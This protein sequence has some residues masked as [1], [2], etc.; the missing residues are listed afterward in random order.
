MG[1][2]ATDCACADCVG[3]DC[4]DC[5]DPPGSPIYVQLTVDVPLID[6]TCIDDCD[7]GTG[8]ESSIAIVN[9]PT[10]NGVHILEQTGSFCVWDKEI[11]TADSGCVRNFYN[12]TGCTSLSGTS[13]FDWRLS[14][15]RTTTHDLVQISGR[16][17]AIGSYYVWAFN[18]NAATVG[19]CCR[20]DQLTLTNNNMGALDLSTCDAL[21][22]GFCC[23][24]WDEDPNNGRIVSGAAG[25]DDLCDGTVIVKHLLDCD[26]GI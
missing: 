10:L 11:L 18:G 24:C 6:V 9:M 1:W 23:G 15:I 12:N 19:D 17:A 14:Y 26:E 4:T 2:W 20:D 22:A 8:S 3:D 21:P 16:N 25:V 7:G 5:A 13:G